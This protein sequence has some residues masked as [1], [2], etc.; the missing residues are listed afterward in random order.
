[1]VLVT[2]LRKLMEELIRL[3][4]CWG[5]YSLYDALFLLGDGERT[6]GGGGGGGGGGPCWFTSN[7]GV[8]N[9]CRWGVSV[10]RGDAG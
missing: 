3:L 8:W 9:E 6:G 1:M 4:S 2:I 5:H 10:G 7:G